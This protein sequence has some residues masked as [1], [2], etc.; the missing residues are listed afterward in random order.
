MFR[1][2]YVV[3]K[4]V[5]AKDGLLGGAATARIEALKGAEV[6]MESGTL[7]TRELRDAKRDPSTLHAAPVMPVVLVAPKSVAADAAAA[8]ASPIWGVDAVGASASPYSGAGVT[9]AILDTGI[10]AGHEAFRGKSIVQKDFTGQG[11]GDQN[12]HGTHCA[13][14]VFGSEVGGVRIGVAPGVAKALIGKVLDAQGS[15]STEQ[16]LDGVLWAVR[17]GANVVSMSIGLD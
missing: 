5:G 6:K 8:A 13:G 12:G 15:G 14:T 16:I 17:E 2:R 10:D 9:V 1:Q 7:S 4:A 11:D 3:L